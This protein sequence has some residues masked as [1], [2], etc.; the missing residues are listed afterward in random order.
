MLIIAEDNFNRE[1][2]GH[3]DKFIIYVKDE[4]RAKAIA[5]ILNEENTPEIYYRAVP[6]NYK[7]KPLGSLALLGKRNKP[8]A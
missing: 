2:P 5:S 4:A 6:D 1:G 3:D 7:L 8:P